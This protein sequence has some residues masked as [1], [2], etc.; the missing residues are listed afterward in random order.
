MKRKHS[1]TYPA[2]LAALLFSGIAAAQIAPP[3][4]DPEATTMPKDVLTTNDKMAFL[5]INKDGFISRQE[6]DSSMLKDWKKWDTNNDGVIDPGEF[7]AGSKAKPTN[8]PD[9][10]Y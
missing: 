2:A 5:D 10:K 7:N 6:A 1:N 4:P 8:S 9:V 3:I